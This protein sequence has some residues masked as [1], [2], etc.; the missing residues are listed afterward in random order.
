ME[1]CLSGT[2]TGD[3]ICVSEY[4]SAIECQENAGSVDP[5]DKR[6][7]NESGRASDQV[8]KDEFITY[9]ICFQNTG[10]DTAF[11]V[12]LVDPLSSY[13]DLNTLEML[14]SSHPYTYEITDGPSLVIDFKNILLPDSAT[15]EL[16]SH[17]FI[18]FRVKP[19]TSMIMAPPFQ[20]KPVSF[21]ILMT[22]Y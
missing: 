9:H 2:I 8:D 4:T 5:N 16:A 7:F 3:N 13:L 11:T 21:L 6:T 1:H 12:R 15:N 20:T 17:G 18:K 14:S 19:K 22:L 10:T